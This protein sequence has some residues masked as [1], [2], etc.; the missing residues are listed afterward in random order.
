MGVTKLLWVI[1][2]NEVLQA[3]Q[4]CNCYAQFQKNAQN[5]LRGRLGTWVIKTTNLI[6][7]IK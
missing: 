4:E 3:F 2:A 1:L 5:E 6:Y 7:Q